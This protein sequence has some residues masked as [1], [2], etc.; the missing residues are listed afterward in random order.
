MLVNTNKMIS[1]TQLQKELT[2]KLWDVSETKEPL[3]VLRNSDVAAVIVSSEEYMA[4]KELEEVLEHFEIYEMLQKRMK[5]HD[6]AQIVTLEEIRE[7]YG[8]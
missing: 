3:F 6:P 7:R 8:L 4:L 5:K 2:K 1:V